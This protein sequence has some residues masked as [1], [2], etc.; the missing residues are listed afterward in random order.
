VDALQSLQN[1]RGVRCVCFWC[2]GGSVAESASVG[3]FFR[4]C[5]LLPKI[6]AQKGAVGRSAV[7]S[8]RSAESRGRGVGV[9]AFRWVRL[10][11]AVGV[12]DFGAV[13]AVACLVCVLF[14]SLLFLCVGRVCDFCLF[15]SP[16]LPAFCGCKSLWARLFAFKNRP[17]IWQFC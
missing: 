10:G 12:C 11:C 8:A 9:C 2:G 6:E 4:A 17:G 15:G 14:A 5:F 1:G 7:W 3:V 13:F 16:P